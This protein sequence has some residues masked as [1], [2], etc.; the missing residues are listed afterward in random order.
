[1]YWACLAA[2]HRCDHA[3]H[4]HMRTHIHKITTSQAPEV[5][6]S[7]EFAMG[8]WPC[9]GCRPELALWQSALLAV[10]QERPLVPP[11]FM[12]FYDCVAAERPCCLRSPTSLWTFGTPKVETGQLG[13][14][15]RV[16]ER[17]RKVFTVKDTSPYGLCCPVTV[18]T[19]DEYCCPNV[20]AQI[21]PKM[22]I[23]QGY[24]TATWQ[25]EASLSDHNYRPGIFAFKD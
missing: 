23:A 15:S 25:L 12:S 19:L 6:A 9:A 22:N 5:S 1:M 17:W 14:A 10:G 21:G 11:F 4:Y 18:T 16:F 2:N 7:P 13:R 8:L 3:V 20:T 24:R